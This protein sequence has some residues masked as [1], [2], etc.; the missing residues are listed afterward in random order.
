ML[1]ESINIVNR[2]VFTETTQINSSKL[3]YR[4]VIEPDAPI[5]GIETVAVI[6]E[7]SFG[8]VVFRR[9]A[10]AEEVGEGARLRNGAAEVVVLV[11]GD[12]VAGFIY[13]LRDVAVVVEGREVEL[14][15]ARHDKQAADASRT[16]KRIG[17]VEAPEVLNLGDVG[18]APLYGVNGFVNQVPVVVDEG[19]LLASLPFPQFDGQRRR[20]SCRDVEPLHGLGRP[21][22]AVVVCVADAESAVGEGARGHGCQ[23]ILG[24][25]GVCPDA[26]GGKT[27]VGVVVNRPRRR[28]GTVRSS[29]LVEIVVHIRVC[30]VVVAKEQLVADVIVHMCKVVRADGGGDDLAAIVVGECGVN[31]RAA[32][33]PSSARYRA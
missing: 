12:D 14:T 11:S 29:D 21:A 9:E 17:K 27:S 19:A 13:V 16:L 6:V 24:V 15:V 32:R 8:I 3:F 5:R 26:V 1:P 30:H 23:L 7:P 10:V 18:D 25:V 22:A 2:V 4:I 31:G 28:R 33:C 20:R